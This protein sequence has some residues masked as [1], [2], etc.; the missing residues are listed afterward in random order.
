ML[1]ASSVASKHPRQAFFAQFSSR[2]MGELSSMASSDGILPLVLLT[3]GLRTPAHLYTALSAKH[4]HLLGIGRGSVL[5]PGLPTVLKNRRKDESEAELYSDLT[6]FKPE[7]DLGLSFTERKPWRW[8]WKYI[9]KVKLIGAG[10]GMA[11]YVVM[12]RRLAKERIRRLGGANNPIEG[13]EKSGA[14]S[15]LSPNCNIGGL[16][17][18]IEMW[19]W[20]DAPEIQKAHTVFWAILAVLIL[21]LGLVTRHIISY[22]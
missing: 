14:N 8:I 6:P 16:G 20:A 9:P 13:K 21:C 3:G 11:W 12:I 15:Y 1:S 2:L 19:M 18:I 22:G 5:C 10:I 7:P 4:A 17:A